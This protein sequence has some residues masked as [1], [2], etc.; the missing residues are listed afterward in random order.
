MPVSLRIHSGKEAMIRKAAGKAGKT[1]TAF[2]LEAIDEKLGLVKNREKMVRE[3]AGWMTHEEA[4]ELR[5]SH[6]VFSEVHEGDWE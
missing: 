2:I 3:L 5:A 1:K 4:D 6:R